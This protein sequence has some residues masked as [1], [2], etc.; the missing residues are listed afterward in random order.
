[1]LVAPGCER[2][3]V[4]GSYV[5][6]FIEES[7]CYSQE[8]HGHEFVMMV[9]LESCFSFDVVLDLFYIRRWHRRPRMT[10]LIRYELAYEPSPCF[11]FEPGA[12]SRF[13]TGLHC[14]A[15]IPEMRDNRGNRPFILLNFLPVYIVPLPSSLALAAHPSSTQPQITPF[16]WGG[17]TDIPIFRPGVLVSNLMALHLYSRPYCEPG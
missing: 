11:V 14:S 7:E 6:S 17:C 4:L 12:F 16:S 9:D 3:P 10:T 5:E 8:P 1:M 15:Y 13:R 2:T